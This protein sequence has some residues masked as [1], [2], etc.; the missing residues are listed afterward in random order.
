VHATEID[1]ARVR[2]TVYNA[3]RDFQVL[4]AVVRL[5][6]SQSCGAYPLTISS[7]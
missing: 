4:L 5:Q 1:P 6:A 7:S 3:I 2:R